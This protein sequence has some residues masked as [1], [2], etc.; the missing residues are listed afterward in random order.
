MEDM[1]F[2]TV[3]RTFCRCCESEIFK[4]SWA[5]EDGY[6]NVF[7]SEK[8]AHEYHEITETIVDE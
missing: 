8:C 3:K 1:E 2:Q 7:C 5:Y 6:R 4:G